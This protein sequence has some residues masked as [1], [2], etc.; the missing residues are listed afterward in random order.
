LAH[1][2]NTPAF[3]LR[4][5]NGSFL[6]RNLTMPQLCKA[7]FGLAMPA[8]S[9][10]VD[11][12]A[13][14]LC[15]SMSD[16]RPFGAYTP[17][18]SMRDLCLNTAENLWQY[19]LAIDNKT[20]NINAVAHAT[21]FHALCAYCDWNADCPKFHDGELQPEWQSELDRLALLK[22]SRSALD[23]E[24]EELEN[25]LKDAYALSNV[26]GWINTGSH[27]FRVASSNG[28]RTLNRERLCRELSAFTR[29][30]DK[31]DDLLTRC[32]QEGR[33][34]SRLVINEIH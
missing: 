3:S 25:A 20:L 29:G 13:W 5:E 26:A 21:G 2:W 12:E 27:R 28:R 22:N 7:H 31:A 14:V 19:K 32:E 34:F 17:D 33:A 6:H 8:E 4:D 23:S 15:F 10:S 11:I 30:E 1:L 18:T 9:A 24:I 16:A